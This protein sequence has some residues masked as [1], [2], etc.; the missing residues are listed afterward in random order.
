MVLAC[1]SHQPGGRFLPRECDMRDTLEGHKFSW[2]RDKQERLVQEEEVA[3]IRFEGAL[4]TRLL[5]VA[6]EVLGRYRDLL[7]GQALEN[8][9]DDTVGWILVVHLQPVAVFLLQGGWSYVQVEVHI[10]FLLKLHHQERV[11]GLALS[12]RRFESYHDQAVDFIGL[13]KQEKLLNVLKL[14]LVVIRLTTEAEGRLV[15]IDIVATSEQPWL[16][17]P[18]GPNGM[19]T[20]HLGV[21]KRISKNVAKVSPAISPISAFS[22]RVS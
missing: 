16:T 4:D 11:L 14:N 10:L 17:I 19:N 7:A 20:T 22:L 12:Q 13:L 2:L 6:N 21:R 1:E 3:F 18:P 15:H 9:R 8:I 5:M